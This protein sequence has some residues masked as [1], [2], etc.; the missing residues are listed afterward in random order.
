[1]IRNISEE[2]ITPNFRAK[3]S[4]KM[5]ATWFS[6]TLVTTWQ[7]NPEDHSPGFTTV[8]NLNLI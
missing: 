6:K 3:Y 7:H 1:M 4:L 5:E 2:H 8:K